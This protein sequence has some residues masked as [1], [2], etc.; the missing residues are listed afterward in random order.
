VGNHVLIPALRWVLTASRGVRAPKRP[1]EKKGK[2]VLGK[3]S[4]NCFA[5]KK[6]VLKQPR[7]L[8]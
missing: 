2:R 8:S 6:P 3:K 5:L 1:G 7:K 4:N